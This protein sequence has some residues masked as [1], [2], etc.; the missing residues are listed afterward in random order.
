MYRKNGKNNVALAPTLTARTTIT[1]LLASGCS[2]ID[3]RN[4]DRLKSYA[5]AADVIL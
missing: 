3:V 2:I 4:D 5:S 1:V